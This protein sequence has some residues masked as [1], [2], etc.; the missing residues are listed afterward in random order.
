MKEHRSSVDWEHYP[1]D[2]EFYNPEYQ[3]KIIRGYIQK[4]L[5]ILEKALRAEK[6][7]LYPNIKEHA[8]K[9]L[10]KYNRGI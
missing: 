3:E 7:I 4:Y 1:I 2:N 5:E 8:E 10:K 6:P 9:I